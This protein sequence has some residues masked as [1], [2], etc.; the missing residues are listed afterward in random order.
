LSRSKT[1]P[2]VLTRVQSKDA[3]ISSKEKTSSPEG[4]E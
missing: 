1:G 4:S 3:D 2:T